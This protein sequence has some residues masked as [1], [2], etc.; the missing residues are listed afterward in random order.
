MS[1][2]ISNED[3]FKKLK[4]VQKRIEGL[5][6]KVTGTKGRHK[7]LEAYDGESDSLSLEGKEI[8]DYLK[9]KDSLL[10]RDV[11]RRLERMGYDRTRT[12]IRQFVKKLDRREENVK[13]DPDGY[14]LDS[15]GSKALVKWVGES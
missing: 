4:Y 15:G 12:S 5:D 3:I 7:T 14:R 8:V 6:S 13:Y 10:I 11:S 1:E 2:D 9:D